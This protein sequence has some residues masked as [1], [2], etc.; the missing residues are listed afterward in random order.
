[1]ITHEADLSVNKIIRNKLYGKELM[2]Y[3]LNSETKIPK[4]IEELIQSVYS[5]QHFLEA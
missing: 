1:M 5:R 3:E 2:E 4:L